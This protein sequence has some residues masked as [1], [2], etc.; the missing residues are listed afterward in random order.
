MHTKATSD[1]LVASPSPFTGAARLLDFYGLFDRYNSSL[2]EWEADYRALL[3]DWCVVG[4]ELRSAMQTFESS[5]PPEQLSLF[6]EEDHGV[7]TNR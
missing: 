7:V 3:S 1:F 4:Q 6:S 2:N 5:V